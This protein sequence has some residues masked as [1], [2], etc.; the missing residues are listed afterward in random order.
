[1]YV[2]KTTYSVMPKAMVLIDR[3]LEAVRK[4]AIEKSSFLVYAALLTYWLRKG[5]PEVL[6]VPNGYLQTHAG[7]RSNTS[8]IKAKDELDA[9]GL[10][11]YHRQDAGGQFKVSQ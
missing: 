5:T 9:C 7:L 6:E 11:K 3:G 2:N 1:M 4:R 8:L 10:I